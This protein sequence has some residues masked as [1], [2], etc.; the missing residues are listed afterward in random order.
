MPSSQH[1]DGALCVFA[2]SQPDEWESC[3]RVVASVGVSGTWAASA[4]GRRVRE[5]GPVWVCVSKG[6]EGDWW[7]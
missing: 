3:L 2:L 4:G 7:P 1:R 6:S 5:K